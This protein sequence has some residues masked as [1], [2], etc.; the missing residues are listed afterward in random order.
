MDLYLASTKV[1]DQLYSLDLATR[2]QSENQSLSEWGGG[3]EAGLLSRG[4]EKETRI[5]ISELHLELAGIEGLSDIKQVVAKGTDIVEQV[6]AKLTTLESLSAEQKAVLDD[7]GD[8]F[9]YCV[10]RYPALYI[11]TETREGPHSR[12]L[13]EEHAQ[14]FARFEEETLQTRTDLIQKRCYNSGLYPE[15]GH[16]SRRIEEE[17]ASDLYEMTNGAFERSE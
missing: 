8:F 2:D 9:Y 5:A 12:E 7:L 13:T 11:S 6:L 16:H 4:D 17:Q 14:R 3:S 10:W 1:R 15:S